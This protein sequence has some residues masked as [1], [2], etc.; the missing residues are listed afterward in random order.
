MTALIKRILIGV[1]WALI[2]LG[3][4]LGLWMAFDILS[5]SHQLMGGPTFILRQ[6]MTLLMSML[7]PVA[8]GAVLLLAVGIYGRL[9]EN[10]A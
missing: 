6:W 1:A 8:Q 10:R 4:L 3:P 7:G 5:G 2:G 9:V